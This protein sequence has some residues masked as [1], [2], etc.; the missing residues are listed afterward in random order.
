MQL[1]CRS[2]RGS[3]LEPFLSLGTTPLANSLLT[4]AALSQAEQRYPLDLVFCVDCTLVQITYSVPPQEMFEEYAYFSSFADTVVE[5]ARAI[6]SRLI[7]ERQLGPDNLAM[8]IASNDGYLLRN[9]VDAGVPVLGID[10][11]RNVATVAEDN[12]VPTICDFF[13]AALAGDRVA[14]VSGRS[15]LHANNVLA[16]VPDVNG[17]VEASRR[18]LPTTA[19]PSSRRRTFATLSTSS[20]STRST[21]STSFTTHCTH[22]SPLRSERTRRRRCRAHSDPRRI[23]A[24]LRR[25]SGS[26]PCPRQSASSSPRNAPSG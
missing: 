15:V 22:W 17:V 25:A 14:R 21:T 2:C 8:E 10:P 11:A 26:S 19:S 3:R 12:G 16:H 18:F 6:M 1:L 4:D 23:A 9:Y 24:R 13:G 20:S 7:R 5:N